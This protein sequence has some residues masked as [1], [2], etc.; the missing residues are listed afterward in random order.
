M[1]VAIVHDYIKEYGGAERVLEALHEIFPEAPVFTSVYIPSFLGPHRARFEGWDIRTSFLQHIPF[2]QKLISPFRLLSPWV[3][4]QFDLSGF[5]VVIV[6]ATGAYFP[7]MV[8]TK[9]K[10]EGAV[11]ICYCHTPPRYLYGYATA[12]DWKRHRFFAILGGMV[13]HFLRMVD[14]EVSKNVDYYI[15]NSEEVAGRILK[16]YRRG[17]TVIYPPVELNRSNKDQRSKI[18]DQKQKEEEYYLAGGRLA[19]AKHT[20]I[21]IQ[22]CEELGVALK[23]FG[24]GFAGYEEKIK[25]PTFAKG[26]GE[27]KQNSKVEFLGEVSDEEKFE[28]MRNATAFIFAGED[29]DFGIVPVEAMGSGTPVIAYKSGGVKETVVEGNPSAGSGQGTGV[30]FDELSRESLI[31]AIRKFEKTKILPDDCRKQAEKFG[32]ER[33]IKEIKKFV[34]KAY[35]E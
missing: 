23:V 19:R 21:I 2:K 30:F 34:E 9:N 27:A 29:E 15:A 1:K 11:Q 5:D 6:S 16:F 20:D 26:Y 3:F 7:N 8:R 31:G 35:G 4:N 28:L 10:K 22:A 13:N 14:F 24:R 18:K 17:A 12:R 32:K 33:F 25:D